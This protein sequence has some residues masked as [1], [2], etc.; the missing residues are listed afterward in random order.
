M[1]RH[2]TKII[3]LIE[4]V[5]VKRVESKPTCFI[6]RIIRVI[7]K[8]TRKIKWIAQTHLFHIISS[9]VIV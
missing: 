6:I 7:L 2:D 4:R 1:C 5:R 3:N 9:R 8:L